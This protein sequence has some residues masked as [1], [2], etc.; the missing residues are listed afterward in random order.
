M[1]GAPQIRSAKTG[2]VDPDYPSSTVL[3]PL[4]SYSFFMMKARMFVAQKGE[5]G[6]GGKHPRT[7]VGFLSFSPTRHHSLSRRVAVVH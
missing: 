1:P 3:A 4:P 5:E 6:G 2:R 7:V